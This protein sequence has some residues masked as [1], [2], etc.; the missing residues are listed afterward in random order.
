MK[1]F[2]FICALALISFNAVSFTLRHNDSSESLL[3]NSKLTTNENFSGTWVGHCSNEDVS[4]HI[5][6]DY[7]KISIQAD[8][9]DDVSTFF[10][11]A[12]ITN[13][14]IINK[15]ALVNT[16]Y[17]DLSGNFL[18]L[19]LNNIEVINKDANSGYHNDLM[20]AILIKNGDVIELRD[21]LSGNGVTCTLSKQ[22]N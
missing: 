4:L 1:K 18:F 6:Q 7:E 9:D 21:Y 22:N 20:H 17:A 12:L 10:I 3:R 11:N 14:K 19:S 16:S 5:I 2:I 13:H 15:S 8:E